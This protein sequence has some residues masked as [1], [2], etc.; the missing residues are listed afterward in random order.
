[1]A[2]PSIPAEFW[3][4]FE[5]RL[6]ETLPQL[7]DSIAGLYAAKLT[8]PELDALLAFYTSPIGRRFRELQPMLVTESTA[9]GQRWGMRI[10]AEIGASLQRP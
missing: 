8:Q 10:G 7:I 4:R 1:M 5:A 2:N 3:T 9:I 6:T